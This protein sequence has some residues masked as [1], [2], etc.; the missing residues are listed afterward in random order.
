[1]SPPVWQV[2]LDVSYLTSWPV[3]LELTVVPSFC[4]AISSGFWSCRM[5]VPDS[6]LAGESAFLCRA[7]FCAAPVENSD[8]RGRGGKDSD[9]VRKTRP[10]MHARYLHVC[11][12][13]KTGFCCTG[14]LCEAARY[15]KR[16]HSVP[17]RGRSDVTGAVPRL[18]ESPQAHLA[19]FFFI[20]RRCS[21]TCR[22][23][24]C[25]DFEIIHT[26]ARL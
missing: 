11:P 24:L 22:V 1:M 17:A 16:A 12:V 9:F 18:C 5:A 13:Q 2:W 20:C 8:W 14:R 19:V 6:V 23:A 26:K 7:V 15:R 3:P 21:V 10:V 25:Y 4:L